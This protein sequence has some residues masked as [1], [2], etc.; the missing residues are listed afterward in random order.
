MTPLFKSLGT[1][2]C[3]EHSK[4]RTHDRYNDIETRDVLLQRQTFDDAGSQTMGWCWPLAVVI[5]VVIQVNEM[6]GMQHEDGTNFLKSNKMTTLAD[7]VEME[8]IHRSRRSVTL[9]ESEKT[10]LVDKHNALRRLQG[11]S[12]MKH[13]V[14]VGDLYLLTYILFNMYLKSA[15]CLL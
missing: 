6:T 1:S 7:M 5:V 12:D 11:A 13:M 8:P 3:S 2:S 10:K 14:S 15:F 4:T 9:S